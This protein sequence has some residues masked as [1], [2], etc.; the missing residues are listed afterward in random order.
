MSERAATAAAAA[1]MWL[2]AT[3]VALGQPE[4]P[5]APAPSCAYASAQPEHWRPRDPDLDPALWQ[6]EARTW[7]ASRAKLLLLQQALLEDTRV[8]LVA[9]T[10]LSNLLL[11]VLA[12]FDGTKA[13]ADRLRF[14]D[15]KPEPCPE[16]VDSSGLPS[17]PTCAYR[18][19]AAGIEVPVDAAGPGWDCASLRR[20]TSYVALIQSFLLEWNR[21]FIAQADKSLRDAAKAWENYV[22]DGYSQYPW[23]LFIN[24]LFTDENA[25]APGQFKLIVLHPSVGVLIGQPTADEV[26]PLA[27]LLM[28]EGLGFVHYTKS[29]DQYFGLGAGVSAVSVQPDALSAALLVHFASLHIGVSYGLGKEIKD[30]VGVFVTFDLTSDLDNAWLRSEIP[31]KVVQEMSE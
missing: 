19:P 22:R 27:G 12:R 31:Q 16:V 10:G 23:E 18:F 28:V 25:W 2:F 26:I 5:A 21:G 7:P 20:L 14:A 24:G 29:H 8:P 3:A 30:E 1:C 9:R 11:D 6:A 17:A 15:F 13:T 4:D